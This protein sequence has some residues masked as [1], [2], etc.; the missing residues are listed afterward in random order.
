MFPPGLGGALLLWCLAAL[1]GCIIYLDR[2]SH[3][4]VSLAW[5]SVAVFLA[6]SLGIVGVRHYHKRFADAETAKG[7]AENSANRLEDEVVSLRS[8]LKATL[9]KFQPRR[10]TAE[11][12]ET[13]VPAL[14]PYAS[15][16]VSILYTMDDETMTYASDFRNVFERAGWL[17][18]E[19][20]VQGMGVRRG[21]SVRCAPRDE[22]AL[23]FVSSLRRVGVG[24]EMS[25][26]PEQP[27]DMFRVTVGNRP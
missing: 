24:V 15:Q 4:S 19:D 26:D 10:L 17:I 11:Q 12:Q 20:I 5:L 7:E 27:H 6:A 3:V 21:L 8:E 13:M 2:L 18:A 14:K 1:T 9:Q 25:E 23:V 22:A 16:R